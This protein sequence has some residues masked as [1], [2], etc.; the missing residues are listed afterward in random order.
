[1]KSSG[2]PW[3]DAEKQAALSLPWELF[4]S[5]HPQ[6]SREA[7]RHTRRQP[8]KPIPRSKPPE[9]LS[10]EEL[11][12]SVVGFGRTLDAAFPRPLEHTVSLA[13]TEPIAVAFLA[14]W[15]IGS[16]GTDLAQIR[17]DCELIAHHPRVYAALGGDPVDNFVL[18]K[19]G[20]AARTQL[21]QVDVQWRLFRYCV[22]LI[23]DSLLWV[24]AGNHD[25]WTHKVAGIDGVLSALYDIPTVYTGEGGFITLK[26]GRQEYRVYR[27]H[28]PTRFSSGYNQT[29]F[30]KQMLRM[31]TIYEFDI[32]V[33]EHLHEPAIEVFEYRPGTK[34]DRIA[35]CCG[36][37]KLKDAFAESLGYYGGG[38]GIPT[39]ILYPDQRKM[40]PFYSLSDAITVL[41][42][43]QPLS[44][45]S[46]QV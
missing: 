10:D 33:S 35:I 44:S 38:Y 45:P 13:T 5:Q 8:Q 16:Q 12:D 37:Y 31:G 9:Q 24:S 25:A 36:T 28:K 41:D 43:L 32:G 6:R 30:L 40:L 22:K 3:T 1:M 18:D 19:M 39:V 46:P 42:A 34:I 14:D 4:H 21:I 20:S 27:K 15:H 29:H 11:F 17:A 26:I 2:E 7:W 23:Q